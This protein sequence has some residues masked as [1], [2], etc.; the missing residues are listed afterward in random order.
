MKK[1]TETEKRITDETRELLEYLDEKQKELT[2]IVWACLYFFLPKASSQGFDSTATSP[3]FGMLVTIVFRP[4]SI[5][6][7]SFI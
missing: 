7:T 2:A 5:L 3:N 6:H 1:L 4:V